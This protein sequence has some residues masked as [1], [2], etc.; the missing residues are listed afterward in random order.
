MDD[1]QD[2]I[3]STGLAGA[4]GSPYVYP[5]YGAIGVTGAVGSVDCTVDLDSDT[6]YT[7]TGGGIDPQITWNNAWTTA[8]SGRMELRGQD[9][10]L[11]INGRSLVQSLDAIEQRLAILRP[12][13]ELEAQWQQLRELG[14]RYRELEKELL[15]K[16]R[17]WEILQQTLPPTL[18]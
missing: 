17:M 6:V 15:Q 18:P 16:N 13:P 2:S 1:N 7:I 4:Q 11:V 12:N 8:P 5:D 14:D 9:A 3:N 10:D